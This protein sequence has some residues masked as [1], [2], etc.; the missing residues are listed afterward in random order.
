MSS[1][2]AEGF[3]FLWF[4]VGDQELS[5]V[6]RFSKKISGYN[7]IDRCVA[8]RCGVCFL[9]CRLSDWSFLDQLV[10]VKVTKVTFSSGISQIV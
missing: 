4:M 5:W 2:G 10:K 8:D 9:C 7:F 1:E 6:E 3:L